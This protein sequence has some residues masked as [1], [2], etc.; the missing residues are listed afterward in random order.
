MIERT[1]RIGAATA[2]LWLAACTTRASPAAGCKLVERGHGPRGQVALRVERIATGLVVPW[3][4]AFLPGGD[5]LVTERPGRVRLLRNGRLEP[6]PVATIAVAEQGEGGLLGIAA[7][8]RFAE[9]HRFYVYYTGERGGRSVNRL[10]R[11][12]LAS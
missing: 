10:A 3:G 8:P 5:V 12:V 6:A 9:N 4:L 11:Y 7:D 2:A 1:A